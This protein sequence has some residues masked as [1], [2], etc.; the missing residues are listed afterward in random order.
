MQKM[1][2]EVFDLFKPLAHRE[3][4][5]WGG[6]LLLVAKEQAEEEARRA[7]EVEE[8][9]REAAAAAQAARLDDRRAAL[10]KSKGSK[11]DLHCALSLVRSG[12]FTL[13]GENRD[14]TGSIYFTRV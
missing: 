3:W 14:R 10:V 9:V 2:D 11:E 1:V 6:D 13:L 4:L 5:E 12:F 8:G 7:R